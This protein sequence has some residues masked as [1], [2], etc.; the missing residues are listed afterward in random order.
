MDFAE[1][2]N[3]FFFTGFLTVSTTVVLGCRFAVASFTKRPVIALRATFTVLV[4][5]ANGPI[6]P[7]VRS[8]RFRP[9]PPPI[10][11][12]YRKMDSAVK[13]LQ[14]IVAVSECRGQNMVVVGVAV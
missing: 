8:H 2:P 13:H 11:K 10:P 4:L 1:E 7:S 5:G 12:I 3:Y 9:E 14:Q 6:P